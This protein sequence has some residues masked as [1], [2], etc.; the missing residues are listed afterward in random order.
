MVTGCAGSTSKG[1]CVALAATVCERNGPTAAGS[2]QSASINAGDT[3]SHPNE[4]LARIEQVLDKHVRP[5]LR[6]DRGDIAVVGIDQDNIVQV[7]L[8]GACQG[9][10]SSIFTLSMRVE[11]ILKAQVPEIRFLEAVP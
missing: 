10:S 11:A 7:R 5:D 6:S 9:C 4:L 3:S 8:T 1:P 2:E